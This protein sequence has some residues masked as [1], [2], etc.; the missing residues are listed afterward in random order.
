MFKWLS[1]AKTD[2]GLLNNKDDFAYTLNESIN[3][4]RKEVCDYNLMP[5]DEPNTSSD[6]HS[7]NFF[8]NSGGSAFGSIEKSSYQAE[9]AKTIKSVI[10]KIT[11]NNGKNKSS[12]VVSKDQ[13]SDNKGAKIN[14]VLDELSIAEKDKP[15]SNNSSS[16]KKVLG[17]APLKLSN[18][19]FYIPPRPK[20]S[21]SNSVN[22]S[23]YSSFAFINEGINKG[24]NK[25][26]NKLEKN[27]SQVQNHEAKNSWGLIS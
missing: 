7:N 16:D 19:R 4:E 12:S 24:R 2:K 23:S 8:Y 3:Y 22:E 27:D 13:R 6:K 9:K 15:Q 25:G 21:C 17:Q 1:K 26:K 18:A 14:Q 20:M 11:D 10:D 5:D